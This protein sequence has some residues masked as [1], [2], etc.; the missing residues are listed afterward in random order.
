MEELLNRYW[1]GACLAG[2]LHVFLKVI[3]FQLPVEF[4]SCHVINTVDIYLYLQGILNDELKNVP[5]TT[6]QLILTF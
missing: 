2:L 5:K 1:I 4:M 6:Q 3:K